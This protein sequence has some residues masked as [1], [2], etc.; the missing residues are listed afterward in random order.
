MLREVW[1]FGMVQLAGLIGMNLAGWWLTTLVARADTTLVQMSFF[2]IANQMRNIVGLGPSLLTESSYAIMAASHGSSRAPGAGDRMPSS[3]PRLAQAAGLPAEQNAGASRDQALHPAPAQ[4]ALPAPGPSPDQTPDQTPDQVMALCTYFATVSSLVLSALGIV[5]VPWGLT[6]LYGT[7]YRAGAITTAVGLAIA[8]VHM[9][10]SPAAARLTIVS[11][12]TAGVINTLWAVFV[13]GAGTALLLHGGAAWQAMAVYL[14]A[15]LLSSGLVLAALVRHRCVP[16]G[17]L[18]VV[19]LGAATSLG[20]AGLAYLRNVDQALVIPSTLAML[21]L[22]R[23]RLCGASL[24]RQTPW[25]AAIDC[26]GPPAAARAHRPAAAGTEE[27]LMP[28]LAT[29]RSSAT[30]AL[31]GHSPAATRTLNV[32]AYV[33]LRN[34]HASTGAGRVARQLVEHL[35]ALPDLR[36][37]ILADAGDHSRIL[38]LVGAPWSG[39]TY[40]LFA[41]DTSRQQARWLALNTPP[42]ES[43]WPEGR[44]A[45]LHGRILRSHA[46]DALDRHPP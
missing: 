8:I 17:M 31:A 29:P 34:I 4:S 23:G 36:F 32:L 3:D 40:S 26:R 11:I 39:Y 10:N 19:S 18:A 1:S 42:A 22:I 41:D 7:A 21:A 12:K 38:P 15:H 44:S 16:P 46:Q 45:L 25:L 13:A 24:L 27:R 35:A 2:A 33:H 28:S 43:F 37:R 5:V 30:P 20:L 14:G 9:G 6:L